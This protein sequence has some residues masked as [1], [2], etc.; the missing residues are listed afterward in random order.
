MHRLFDNMKSKS[1]AT[2]KVIMC[3][4]KCHK[5]VYL[6]MGDCFALPWQGKFLSSCLALSKLLPKLSLKFMNNS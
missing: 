4:A 5:C 2:S 6:Q 1:S 3:S